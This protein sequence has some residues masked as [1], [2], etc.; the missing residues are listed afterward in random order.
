MAREVRIV[1]GEGEQL[2]YEAGRALEELLGA[3]AGELAALDLE[4]TEGEVFVVRLGDEVVFDA[5]SL[6]HLPSPGELADRLRGRLRPSG[7]DRPPDA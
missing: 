2:A 6:G 3:F 1:Y 4:P 7:G 5:A